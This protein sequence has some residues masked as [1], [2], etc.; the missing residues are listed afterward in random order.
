MGILESSSRAARPGANNGRHAERPRVSSAASM[1]ES[2]FEAH[3]AL[4]RSGVALISNSVLTSGLGVAYWLVAAHVMPRAELGQGSS[5]L[6]A[7]WTVSALAQ[8]NYMR[9]LPGL[10]PRARGGADRV[11]AR[12]YAHVILAS[13]FAGLAFAL[14][15]PRV[16]LTFSYVRSIPGFVFLF[17]LSVPIYS[18]FCIEDAVLATVRRAGIIP[19]EN[20]TYG[21]LKLLVLM[22]FVVF[23]GVRGPSHGISITLSWILPLVVIVVPV[24]IFLF[25]RAVPRAAADFPL[26]AQKGGAWVRYD[27]MGYLFW[28]FGTLP[29][30]VLVIT[31]LGPLQTAAFY[32]P[33]TIATAVDVMTLNL[34]N[35]LTAEMSRTRGRFTTATS[36][37]VWRVWALTALLGV[38]L[39]I[40][41]PYVLDLFGSDYRAAATSI[42]RVLMLAVLPRSILF[43]GI[44]AVRARAASA[45]AREGGGLILALQSVTC[46]ATFAFGVPAMHHFGALGMAISWLAASS[47]AAVVAVSVI[48]FPSLPEHFFF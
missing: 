16:S 12:I 25:T 21:V 42:F 37:F 9:S 10:L 13:L 19:F 40:I 38:G 6:S 4:T 32:V 11:L 5:L 17:A 22:A 30:P 35:S 46:L 39:A 36:L 26:T 43:L 28:L 24:N 47:L 27:F 31:V 18:I 34:G 20:A 33:F 1:S 41:A 3:R 29:L 8:L 14:V 2:H 44:A 15:A 48:R 45:R 23:V 7:L